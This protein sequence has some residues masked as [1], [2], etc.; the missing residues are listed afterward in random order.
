M[1][2]A[3]VK[4][5]YESVVT[6]NLESY[7]EGY[8]TTAADDITDPYRKEA[9]GLYDSLNAEQKKVLMCVVEQTMIDTISSVLGI[10]DGSSTLGDATMEPKLLI[11][12]VDTEGELQDYFLEFIE[13]Q[14]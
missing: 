8:E 2:E 3:F 5:L 11:N 1:N 13:E 10:L 14:E 6:E 9:Q 4:A 12:D 7:Q